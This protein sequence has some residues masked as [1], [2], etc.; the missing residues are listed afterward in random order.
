MNL[1]NAKNILA[2]KQKKKGSLELVFFSINF[3]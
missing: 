3:A 2:D 1:E